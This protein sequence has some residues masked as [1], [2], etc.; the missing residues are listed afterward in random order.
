MY[1]KQLISAAVL[2]V[3]SVGVVHATEDMNVYQSL[4]GVIH[5]EDPDSKGAMRITESVGDYKTPH[6]HED[7]CTG[8]GAFTIGYLAENYIATNSLIK[9]LNAVPPAVAKEARWKPVIQWIVKNRDTMK[10]G[11]DG[12]TS[13]DLSVNDVG[14]MQIQ[15]SEDCIRYTH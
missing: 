3:L 8:V 1:I 6:G 5:G 7:V 13:S 10:T 12:L 2:S 15:L 9:A 4:Q 14:L 11:L